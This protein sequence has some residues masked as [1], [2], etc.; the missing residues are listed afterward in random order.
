ML[1]QV[2]DHG[3]QDAHEDGQERG[4]EDSD[5]EVD[6][7][8]VYQGQLGRLLVV[9]LFEV[10]RFVLGLDVGVG[11]SGGCCRRC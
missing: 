2:V 11:G 10:C 1:P 8:A 9:L 3:V 6:A 7:Y 4:D 5:E